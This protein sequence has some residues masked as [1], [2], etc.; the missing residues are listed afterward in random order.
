MTVQQ[1]ID[2]LQKI[3]DKT[4]DVLVELQEGPGS[5]TP[6]VGEVSCRPCGTLVETTPNVCV[7]QR[8]CA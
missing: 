3:E 8:S 1:L 4:Q 5:L 7:L 2:A 6:I